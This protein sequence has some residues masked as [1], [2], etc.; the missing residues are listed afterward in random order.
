MTAWER[1][2]EF[3]YRSSLNIVDQDIYHF[4]VTNCLG[5][6]ATLSLRVHLLNPSSELSTL[7]YAE[8]F[9][10]GSATLLWLVLLLVLAYNLTLTSRYTDCG[11]ARVRYKQHH[12]LKQVRDWS[13]DC[14]SLL[15]NGTMRAVRQVL[16]SRAR[17]VLLRLPTHRTS[18]APVLHQTQTLFRDWLAADIQPRQIRLSH[19]VHSRVGVDARDR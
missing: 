13:L 6:A 9:I 11:S 5:H 7:Q 4:V 15:T 1:G 19:H 18:N 17:T 14:T 3:E 8:P 2:D 12:V 10:A 16:P